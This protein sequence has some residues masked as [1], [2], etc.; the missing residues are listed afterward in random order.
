MADVHRTDDGGLAI[1]LTPDDMTA[2]GADAE[3]LPYD[4]RDV[5]SGI[6]AARTGKLTFPLTVVDTTVRLGAELEGLRT[7][8]VREL[9][10]HGISFGELANLAG[11]SRSGGQHWHRAATDD[12]DSREL[13]ATGTYGDPDHPGAP[14]PS[15]LR[16]WSRPY[17]AYLPVDVTKPA[18]RPGAVATA[19]PTRCDVVSDPAELGRDELRGRASRALVPWELDDRWRPLIPTGRTGRTGRLCRRWGENAAADP[20]VVTGDGADRRVLLIRRAD[21]GGRDDGA[22]AVWAL[23]G[24]HI[25]R[26][27]IGTDAAIREACEETGVDIASAPSVVLGRAV[28]DDWRNTDHAWMAS[29]HVLFRLDA[30]PDPRPGDDA[31][32]ARWFPFPNMATLLAELGDLGAD[33]YDGHRPMLRAALDHLGAGPEPAWKVVYHDRNETRPG[34]PTT[35]AGLYVNLQDADAEVHRLDAAGHTAIV[36]AANA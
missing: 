33:L 10:R 35:R 24:G 27:E 21:N 30:A 23:P 9:A 28:V 15:Y 1:T 34:Y 31:A 22:R 14:V 12:P 17:P 16:S 19:D 32:E 7:A 25:D 20:I 3:L 11:L 6:V 36:V 4:L 26:G 2:L 18:F 5:V 29:E 13:W 8:T